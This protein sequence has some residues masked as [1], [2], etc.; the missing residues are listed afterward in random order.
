M[1]LSKKYEGPTLAEAS[2]GSTARGPRALLG[3]ENTELEP[4]VLESESFPP[5]A[6]TSQALAC[7]ARTLRVRASFN[8]KPGQSSRDNARLGV[9]ARTMVKAGWAHAA[10]QSAWSVPFFIWSQTIA[11]DDAELARLLIAAGV[12]TKDPSEVPSQ[13]LANT[14]LRQKGNFEV[15]LSLNMALLPE[16]VERAWRESSSFD[17]VMFS[18]LLDATPGAC[19][20]GFD[21]AQTRLLCAV[22]ISKG[23]RPDHPDRDGESALRRAVALKCPRSVQMLLEL[24]CDPNPRDAMGRTPL[25]LICHLA[26]QISHDKNTDISILNL[27]LAHPDCDKNP[28]DAQ[29]LTPFD[30]ARASKFEGGIYALRPAFEAGQLAQAAE[31]DFL[32]L[33]RAFSVLI[34]AGYEL[35]AP[36]GRTINIEKVIEESER[37]GHTDGAGRQTKKRL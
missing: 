15:A 7:L 6:G 16:E 9:L 19:T 14:A 26:G 22:W 28:G 10:Q 36:D 33:G 21:E 35:R 8:K 25:H 30:L 17:R 29:G 18:A 3:V 24:G 32:E 13:W 34:R 2:P 20:W 1:T 11:Q 12:P 4:F 23:W 31:N 27:L 5:Q 37:V